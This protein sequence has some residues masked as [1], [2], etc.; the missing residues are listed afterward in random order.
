MRKSLAAALCG[1]LLL[2]AALAAAP[3]WRAVVT[4]VV[5]GDSVRVAPPG[6]APVEV[7]LEGIDAPEI[8]QAGGAAARDALRELVQG[9]EVEVRPKGRD[10][11]GRL[12]AT[13][14]LDGTNVNAHQ[15]SE[16]QA[17]SLRYKW[18]L[19]PYVKEE[20]L[21][22]AL[23]RGLQAAGD[24]ERP[25]DFRQRH[26]PCQG[27]GVV[28]VPAAAALPGASPAATAAP[29]WRCDGR[30]R[31][32]QM[33]SCEEAKFFLAHCPGVEMDGDHDGI[34]C[35]QQWCH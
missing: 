33:H 14:V 24:A 32:T 17:W 19:G 1:G 10:V 4:Q 23:R 29:A 35:E 6:G 13:L 31:C 28:A 8:C 27:E 34:P 7:R 12:L 26:G 9:R 22:Q 18:D 11:Y 30:R 5:D 25:R 3:P 20:R 16:G 15:V 2:G 21:A